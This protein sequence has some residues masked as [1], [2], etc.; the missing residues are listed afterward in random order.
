MANAYIRVM[1]NGVK[2]RSYGSGIMDLTDDVLKLHQELATYMQIDHMRLNNL[3]L[4]G[5]SLA[6]GDMIQMQFFRRRTKI[7]PRTPRFVLTFTLDKVRDLPI[8][9]IH[10]ITTISRIQLAIDDNINENAYQQP[11]ID[12]LKYDWGRGK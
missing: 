2:V 8:Q 1:R 7:K 10:P 5:E 9:A 4:P 6:P 3:W 11:I 12:A